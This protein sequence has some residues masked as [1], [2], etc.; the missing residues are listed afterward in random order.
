M[1]AALLAWY[2][3]HRR[4]LPWRAAA[5]ERVDPYHVWLSEVMLQQTRVETVKP[6]Y[7]RWLE[8]FPSLSSL[9]DAPLDDVLK[10]WEGLGYYSR[11]RNLHR[12]VREVAARHLGEIPDDPATFR[13][14]PGVGRYTA[15]AVLSI[16]FGRPEP[17]VDGNVRRVFA[18]WRDEAA[19][20]DA[21]LWA[22][23]A[24]LVPGERPGDLNQS[25][26]E[27]GAT[28]CTPRA[29]RCQECPVQDHC[30]AY[31]AGTEEQ[32][33]LPKKAKPLP[34]EHHA[35]AVVERDGRYLLAR[36]PV[37]ARLGGLWEF[38]GALRR[39]GES[40]A[41]AAERAPL[42]GVGI[43]VRAGEPIA[44]VKHGFTHVTV[45][46][47]AVRCA[48]VGGDER[49]LAYDAWVWVSPEEIALY[50]LPLAQKKIAALV[51]APSLFT[52]LTPG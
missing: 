15:G 21:D 9:A 30:A 38:P 49:A 2:D 43:E 47:H 22:L 26:M 24:A 3:A 35:V 7:E 10:A 44:S 46:Y 14:L 20:R 23:A 8:R 31:R 51:T 5:G 33:P 45:T 39:R 52:T 28:V 34:H 17:L 32:R 29:P 25:L 41:A 19:P 13:A 6:Y 11:A 50:A 16:A 4:D 27:L 37:D 40:T 12:A 36:R 18:R 1:R 42:E 48:S